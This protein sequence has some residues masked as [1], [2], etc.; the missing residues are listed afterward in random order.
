MQVLARIFMART[1]VAFPVRGAAVHVW[2]TLVSNT[3]KTLGEI[4]PVLMDQLITSLASQGVPA[5]LFVCLWTV[6]LSSPV[7]EVA[8]NSC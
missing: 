4:L 8:V 5:Q 6:I 1:D 3:P 2:K 7:W